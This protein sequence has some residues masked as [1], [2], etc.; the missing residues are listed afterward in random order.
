MI[1]TIILIII[2]LVKNLLMLT[3]L[4]CLKKNESNSKTPKFKVNDRAKITKYKNVFSKG[5]TENCSKEIF[6]INSALETSSWTYKPK[7]LNGK[8]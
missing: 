6:I 2:P 1:N 7:D 8:K 4:L 5:S 3:I